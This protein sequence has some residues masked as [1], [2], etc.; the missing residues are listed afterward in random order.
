[1]ALDHCSASEAL[2]CRSK[3][4]ER[5]T[6]RV[7]NRS[8][9]KNVGNRKQDLTHLIQLLI[10]HGSENQR[11]W[12][13]RKFVEIFSQRSRAGRIMSAIEKNCRVV[14]NQL[15]PARMLCSSEAVHDCGV[16]NRKTLNAQRL[17]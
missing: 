7:F 17:S 14:W 10:T 16:W 6:A 5:R 8:Q 2:R 11:Q 12:P 3:H 9:H 1:M 4:L 15:Q 13:R